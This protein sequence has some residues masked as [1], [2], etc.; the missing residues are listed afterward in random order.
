MKPK[1]LCK[2][3]LGLCAGA[4][5]LAMSCAAPMAAV[6]V[7]T[8]LATE[9]AYSAG[10]SHSG[11]S[12][13][14][15]HTDG[16]S[17]SDHSDDHSHDDSTHSG[18]FK[19]KRIARGSD[20]HADGGHDDGGH[21]DGGHDDAGH[22]SGG[23]KGAGTETAGRGAKSGQQTD[24]AGGRPP[25][26]QEGIPEI[27]LGR[28]NVA[29]APSQVLDRAYLEA[30][31]NFTP[32]KVAFYNMSIEEAAA[33]LRAHFRDVAMLDSPL[34][35]LSLLRD[36]LENGNSVLNSLD[37]VENDNLTL[38]AI[39]LGTASDKSIEIVPETAY[40]LSII[41]GYELTEAQATA[42]A[43]DAEIIRAAIAEGHG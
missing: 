15:G 18:G 38:A 32:D 27:E 31:S 11:G 22:S 26:A 37:E 40:A 25:W 14:S 19:G 6:I 24:R 17:G 8:A 5:A 7:V 23:K 28:L 43:N 42:L 12:G 41:L 29:R 34:Q 2:V 13:G 10:G 20:G 39:F 9:P 3:R 1:Q 21:D 4:S 16:A 35:N 30:L 36:I 33:E